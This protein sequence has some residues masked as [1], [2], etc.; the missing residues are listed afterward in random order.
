MI[1]WW[2]VFFSALSVLGLAVLL[3]GF[4]Y[5]YWL[6]HQEGRRLVEQ[7]QS[8][9]FRQV[10][11]LGLALVAAGL[12]GSNDG[13]WELVIWILVTAYSLFNLVLVRR[14]RR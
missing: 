1:P 14:G 7:L 6:A 8:P 9:A 13:I 3:T 5:H 12:A 4:G 10:F 11:W 2:S